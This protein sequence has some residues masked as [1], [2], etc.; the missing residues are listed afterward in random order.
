M[1]RDHNMV[2]EEKFPMS[3]Q[4]Y[5]TGKLLDATECQKL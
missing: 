3:E 1:I 2:V 4:G 5:T